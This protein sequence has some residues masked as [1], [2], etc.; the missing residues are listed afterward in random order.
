MWLGF[1][2]DAVC[3]KITGLGRP[4]RRPPLSSLQLPIQ[5]APSSARSAKDLVTKLLVT[6]PAKRV[7][8]EDALRHRWINAPLTRDASLHLARENM[9]RTLNKRRFKA[10]P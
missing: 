9:R 2:A 8:A 1:S 7:S 3:A 5:D 10:R 6:D 4:A